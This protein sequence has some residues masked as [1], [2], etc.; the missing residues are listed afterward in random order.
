MAVHRRRLTANGAENW[1]RTWPDTLDN[2]IMVS[3]VI[4]SPFLKSFRTSKLIYKDNIGTSKCT[5]FNDLEL[6]G[7]RSWLSS[8]HVPGTSYYLQGCWLGWT[9]LLFMAMLGNDASLRLS[10]FSH[11]VEVRW[12]L[13]GGKSHW[14]LVKQE[15]KVTTG[16]SA[17]ST[18]RCGVWRGTE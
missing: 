13:L 5:A 12:S 9:N 6:G 11:H 17:R 15:T 10:A 2:L 7:L 16:L 18:E 1:R 3:N 8:I 4:S 14:I